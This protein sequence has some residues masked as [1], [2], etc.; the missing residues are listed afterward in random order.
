MFPQVGAAVDTFDLD[1]ARQSGQ[2]ILAYL[3]NGSIILI[4][5]LTTLIYFQFGVR[6][7]PD[8]NAQRGGFLEG[9]AWIGQLFIAVTFGALF[10]GV[11]AAALTALIERIRFLIDL[12]LPFLMQR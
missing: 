4:G 6:K 10:S 3:A 8:K 2:N 7:S 12:F 9:L 1:V 5:T 11:Y